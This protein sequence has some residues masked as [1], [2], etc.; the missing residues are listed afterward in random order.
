MITRHD[1]YAQMRSFPVHLRWNFRQKINPKKILL[2]QKIHRKIWGGVSWAIFW[3]TRF[4]SA[5]IGILD[6]P[7]L[8]KP[9]IHATV[10]DFQNDNLLLIPIQVSRAKSSPQLHSKLIL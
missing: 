5:V 7:G 2:Y 8:K 3:A 10:K 4:I 6:P 1:T 9:K